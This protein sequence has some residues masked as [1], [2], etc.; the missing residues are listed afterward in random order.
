MLKHHRLLR[1]PKTHLNDTNIFESKIHT[2]SG[3]HR[4]VKE[5]HCSYLK[6]VFC[7]QQNSVFL[8][9]WITS[10]EISTYLS[11]WHHVAKTCKHR[12][13]CSNSRYICHFY[14]KGL[15]QENN[16]NF[17]GLQFFDHPWTRH[18]PD[19]SYESYGNI[20]MWPHHL[21]L[22]RVQSCRHRLMRRENV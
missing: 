18:M 5:L 2:E 4:S 15:F 6:N 19:Y 13:C 22:C 20:S 12:K 1:R 9:F 7:K 17:F 16:W 10:K 3:D 8:G 14:L 11:Q 21:P